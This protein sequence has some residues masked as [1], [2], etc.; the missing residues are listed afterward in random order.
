MIDATQIQCLAVTEDVC[1]E[2]CVWHPQSDSVLWT[3]INRGLLHR[4]PLASGSV[5]TWSFGE[6]AT[7]VV[8]TSREQL[9][10]LVLGSK[11][12]VWDTRAHKIVEELYRLP[13]W[14]YVRCNDARVDHAGVL[15][16]GT[17]QNN[18]QV[19]GTTCDVTERRGALFSLAAGSQAKK[20]FDGFGISNT[21]AWSPDGG[22]MYF[23]D[24]LENTLYRG[25]FDPVNSRLEG[26]EVF[27]TGF[28]RGLPDG[29]AVD[30]EGYLW[31]CRYNGSC[32]VRVAPDGSI[33][34]IV[35]TPVK[36]PTTCSF[37]GDDLSTLFF[38]AAESA[39]EQPQNSTGSLFSLRVQVRGLSLTPFRL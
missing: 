2:G 3:D 5:E 37:G 9:I 29:S 8:L 18:V 13:E 11:V 39:D 16:F 25:P 4:Y 19:D 34:G 1:G 35:E 27:C 14:P 33:A 6:P 31:N 36:N 23:G 24:T 17:M 7:S 12:V 38:T 21:L 15:W 22:T 28:G 30:A 32:I 10:V 20:W 26:R